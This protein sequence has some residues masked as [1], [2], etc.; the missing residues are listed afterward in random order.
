MQNCQMYF[1]QMY[2]AVETGEEEEDIYNLSESKAYQI[3]HQV[4]RG[5]EYL[6]KQKIIHGDLAARNILVGE[7]ILNRNAIHIPHLKL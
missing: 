3:C 5:M 6:A 4:A 1:P 7:V 2:N